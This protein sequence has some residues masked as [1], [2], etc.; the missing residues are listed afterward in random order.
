MYCSISC[1]ARSGL[2]SGLQSSR[3]W[4]LASRTKESCRTRG[5]SRSLRAS[6][7][8]LLLLLSPPTPGLSPPRSPA[9]THH[10]L[11][12]HGG[13]SDGEGPRRGRTQRQPGSTTPTP[14]LLPSRRFHFSFRSP[15][16]P[17]AGAW[18]TELRPAQAQP[19]PPPGGAEPNNRA[20]SP[21]PRAAASVLFS[22]EVMYNGNHKHSSILGQAQSLQFS[23]RLSGITNSSSLSHLHSPSGIYPK[24]SPKYGPK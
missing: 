14:Q 12:V 13:D 24:T 10:L 8:P 20:F 1:R 22:Q 19:G 15:A 2:I 5:Q 4:G 6:A 16:P 11:R 23:A 9:R 21:V 17:R 3:C 7:P 18:R